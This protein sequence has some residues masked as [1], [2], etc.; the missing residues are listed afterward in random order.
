MKLSGAFAAEDQLQTNIW[1]GEF[2]AE[3]TLDDGEKIRVIFPEAV[4][5]PTEHAKNK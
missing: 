5:L 1:V 2:H 3:L 4:S